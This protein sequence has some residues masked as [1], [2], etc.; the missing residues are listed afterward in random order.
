MVPILTKEG[1]YI[2]RGGFVLEFSRAKKFSR[3]IVRYHFA[4]SWSTDFL[5][6]ATKMFFYIQK[7]FLVCLPSTFF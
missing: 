5:R 3:F 1:L 4:V 7:R 6:A 2:P